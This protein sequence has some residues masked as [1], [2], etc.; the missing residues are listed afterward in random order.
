MNRP[1]PILTNIRQVGAARDLAFALKKSL[2]RL[3]DP[4]TPQYEREQI[5]TFL[6]EQAEAVLNPK[7]LPAAWPASRPHP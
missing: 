7:P 4:L 6:H 1:A 5:A 2:G 3:T